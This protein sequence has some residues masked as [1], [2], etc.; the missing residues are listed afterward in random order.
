MEWNKSYL[1][2]CDITG[3]R[4]DGRDQ[5]IFMAGATFYSIDNAPSQT[6]SQLKY[7][8]KDQESLTPEMVELINENFWDLF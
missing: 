6:Y 4:R 8:A 3:A 2:W 5:M 1:E 7:L